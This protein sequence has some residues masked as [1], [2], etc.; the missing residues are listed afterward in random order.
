MYRSYKVSKVHSL[1]ES[2]EIIQWCQWIFELEVPEIFS[3]VRVSMVVPLSLCNISACGLIMVAFC[4]P[5]VE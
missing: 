3:G 1:K 5:L 2:V 4:R